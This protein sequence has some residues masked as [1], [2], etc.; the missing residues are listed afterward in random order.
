MGGTNSC[1]TSAATHNDWW[2]IYLVYQPYKPLLR[3]VLYKVKYLQCNKLI[4]LE[5]VILGTKFQSPNSV[6]YHISLKHPR[7][8]YGEALIS[9]PNFLRKTIILK[10]QV[11]KKATQNIGTVYY[12]NR[13]N[14]P[15]RAIWIQLNR[16]IE[17]QK[18][19]QL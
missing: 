19:A 15:N 9:E 3:P 4:L 18:I 12:K 17:S 1:Y 5:K 10:A 7:C 16:Q 13:P 6:P 2:A 8:F 14:M 11:R